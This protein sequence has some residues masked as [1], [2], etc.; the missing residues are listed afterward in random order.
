MN[1]IHR[2]TADR[3]EAHAQIDAARQEL[4]DLLAYLRSDKF[5]G[6][7]GDFVHISTD[8]WPKLVA[9]RFALTR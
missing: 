7:D 9:L 8:L 6:T 5:A 4:N 1:H 2:L 3:D